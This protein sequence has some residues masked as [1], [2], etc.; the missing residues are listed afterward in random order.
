[1]PARAPDQEDERQQLLAELTHQRGAVWSASA[2]LSDSQA[3][4]VP[5]AGSLSV[6][7]IVKHISRT[8]RG[9]MEAARGRGSG[10]AEEYVGTFR[11]GPA[12]TV[13]GLLAGYRKVASDTQ[14]TVSRLGLDHPV[15][16]PR[17]LPWFAEEADAWT[18]R[19]V[20][21]HLAE[22]TARHARHAGLLREA[23]GGATPV[24]A[25]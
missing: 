24:D 4:S 20:L 13:A 21:R 23:V 3:R 16:A 7:G 22:E 8:E 12:D 15:A 19:W 14:A 5:P 10:A 25:A 11:M 1:M 2:G 18:L 17:G 9:W 6:G